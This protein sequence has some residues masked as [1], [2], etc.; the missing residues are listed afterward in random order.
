[1]PSGYLATDN[2]EGPRRRS[3]A[4]FVHGC[5]GER[6]RWIYIYIY[7]A[8]S[9]TDPVLRFY[10]RLPIVIHEKLSKIFLW[11]FVFR[12]EFFIGR[13][14]KS[15][16]NYKLLRVI[17]MVAFVISRHHVRLTN[18]WSMKKCGIELWDWMFFILHCEI[19]QIAYNML[20]FGFFKSCF[21]MEIGVFP[22]DFLLFL[23]ENSA[24]DRIIHRQSRNYASRISS[25]S[26]ERNEA[27]SLM[28]IIR[29]WLVQLKVFRRVYTLRFLSFFFNE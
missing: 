1:M 25:K 20:N 27:K 3:I 2:P 11:L 17:V 14:I 29:G 5:D 7:I 4:C 26:E 22:F 21:V 24:A 10:R 23:V 13:S 16:N 15:H 6:C 9:F 12:L 8:L 18:H 28:W 19:F